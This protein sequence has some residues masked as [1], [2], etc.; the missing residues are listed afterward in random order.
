M[1]NRK[2]ED[3]IPVTDFVLNDIRAR[4]KAGQTRREISEAYKASAG[5]VSMIKA[6]INNLDGIPNPKGKTNPKQCIKKAKIIPPPKPAPTPSEPEAVTK[7]RTELLGFVHS[8]ETEKKVQALMMAGTDRDTIA[9]VVQVPKKVLLEI[10]E[11][12]INNAVPMSN[13]T[14][15]HALFKQAAAGNVRACEVWLRYRA[16]W[17]DDAPMSPSEPADER[18][19]FSEDELQD[20]LKRRGLPAHVLDE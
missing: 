16:G 14:V 20:E 5:W 7:G 12:T 19:V 15:A 17:K 9:G 10:Y 18:R 13:A 4:I 6:R 8:T 1:P 3:R 2:A 11:R